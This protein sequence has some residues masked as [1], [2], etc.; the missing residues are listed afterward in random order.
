MEHHEGKVVALALVTG[1]LSTSVVLA[2]FG[3][4]GVP[5]GVSHRHAA[6]VGVGAAAVVIGLTGMIVLAVRVIRAGPHGYRLTR[7]H[8]VA[9]GVGR[10]LVA[11]AGVV[12]VQHL[13]PWWRH[14]L[15]SGAWVHSGAHAG[16]LR[17]APTEVV[18]VAAIPLA[19]LL[20]LLTASAREAKAR[21]LPVSTA[22]VTAVNGI[23]PLYRSTWWVCPTCD[24]AFTCE[25]TCRGTA[26]WAHDEAAA[27]PTTKDWRVV[28]PSPRPVVT[29]SYESL[30]EPAPLPP[31]RGR[32]RRAKPEL[33]P[34][35][36]AASASEDR[37]IHVD[38][39]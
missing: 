4:L 17:W 2:R 25:S 30:A 13:L 3:A 16:L 8:L 20:A 37:V 6:L 23:G 35:D 7:R 24:R 18:A 26:V 14:E 1:G 31:R 10:P 22:V 36:G 5:H 27:T 28:I 11:V 34:S 15:A 21:R 32:H 12:L 38:L 33:E 19:Y 39:G 29:R 9:A